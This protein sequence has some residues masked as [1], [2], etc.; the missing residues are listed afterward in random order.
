[1]G[2]GGRGTGEQEQGP[3]PHRRWRRWP[4]LSDDSIWLEA[5]SQDEQ[6]Q[7]ENRARILELSDYIVP[8]HGP[9]FKVNE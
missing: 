4:H 6:R 9:M 5:G 3:H 7:R 2:R 8:G 1:M